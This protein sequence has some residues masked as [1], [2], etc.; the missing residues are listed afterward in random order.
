MPPASELTARALDLAEKCGAGLSAIDA[1]L[2]G[3]A[4][5]YTTNTLDET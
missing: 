1:R 2:H 3:V 4:I 5:Y